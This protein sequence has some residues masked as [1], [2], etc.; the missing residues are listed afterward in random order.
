MTDIDTTVIY[1]CLAAASQPRSLTPALTTS[2]LRDC[3]RPGPL[4]TVRL[5]ASEG[6]RGGTRKTLCACAL[7]IAGQQDRIWAS[8]R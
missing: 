3:Q 8:P 1:L 4:F 7:N 2:K 6:C 5:L